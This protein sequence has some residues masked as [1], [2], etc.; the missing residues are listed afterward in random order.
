MEW[1]LVL[2]SCVRRRAF[3]LLSL[4]DRRLEF[5]RVAKTEK[6]LFYGALRL[7]TW[8]GRVGCGKGD[9][10]FLPVTCKCDDFRRSCGVTIPVDSSITTGT[11]TPCSSCHSETATTEVFIVFASNTIRTKTNWCDFHSRYFKFRHS[12]TS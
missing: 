12:S 8:R 3:N 9:Q 5:G 6:G 2:S 1:E 4:T 11:D 7:S 10:G